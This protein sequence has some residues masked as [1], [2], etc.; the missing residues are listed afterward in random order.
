MTKQDEIFA[1]NAYRWED[2]MREVKRK[3]GNSIYIYISLNESA[4]GMR[5]KYVAKMKQAK[6]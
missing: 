3:N 4:F 5:R 6:R 1:Q 2:T